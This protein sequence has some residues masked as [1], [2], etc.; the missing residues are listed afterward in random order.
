MEE[1]RNK[2]EVFFDEYCKHCK[3]WGCK[4]DD[5]PCDECLNT[6]YNENSHKPINF[7]DYEED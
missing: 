3:Y 2:K 4:D 6:P 7:K 5:D 1:P